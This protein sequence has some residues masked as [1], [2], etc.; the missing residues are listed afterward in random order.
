MTNTQKQRFASPN[1]VNFSL[2]CKHY[3]TLEK[4][5]RSRQLLPFTHKRLNENLTNRC[6]DIQMGWFSMMEPFVTQ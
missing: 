1:D 6:L 3:V 4:E 2:R 5:A